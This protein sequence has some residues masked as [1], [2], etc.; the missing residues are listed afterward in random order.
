MTAP[1]ELHEKIDQLSPE[2][3]KRLQEFLERER[4]ERVERHLAALD[5]FA[6]G[7][8]PEEEA[9]FEAALSQRVK[10]RSTG[11]EPG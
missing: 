10:L 11:D 9:A 8:T 5:A 4:Q 6:E 2:G 7:W 3:L 1:Q